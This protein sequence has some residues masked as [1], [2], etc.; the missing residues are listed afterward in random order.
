MF[1]SG[2]NIYRSSRVTALIPRNLQVP[3]DKSTG[4]TGPEH[5]ALE[6]LR[7]QRRI[8]RDYEFLHDVNR[9]K[10]ATSLRISIRPL[11]ISGKST[12]LQVQTRP[13]PKK[14]PE[15]EISERRPFHAKPKG[16]ATKK[17]MLMPTEASNVF[18]SGL[19]QTRENDFRPQA[20]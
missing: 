3:K 11:S 20:P 4:P 2:C 6:S 16:P 8:V 9:P 15:K 1:T 5:E 17:L 13:R 19:G 14:N 10:P 12:L 18:P 7:F